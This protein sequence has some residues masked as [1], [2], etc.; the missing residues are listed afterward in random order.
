[1]EI[2]MEWTWATVGR[3]AIVLTVA[4]IVTS[5]GFAAARESDIRI[6]YGPP[7]DAAQQAM[8]RRL[9]DRKALEDIRDRLGDI[10]LP[11][12]LTIKIADCHGEVDASYESADATVTI[13]YEYL[14]YLQELAR[15]LPPAALREGLT[16]ESYLTGPF[17][18]VVLH[19]LAHALFDLKKIPILG[20]EEDAADQVAALT[21]LRLG[22]EQARRAIAAI[23]IMY[24][25]EAKAEAPTASDFANEH[26]LP[27]Q[28]FYN[29]LCISYG[30]DR[31]TFG[32][33]V[34]KGYL[35]SDRAEQCVAEYQQV[36][37]AFQQLIA[38]HLKGR[39]PT[40]TPQQR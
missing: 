5:A 32:D 17:L 16:P 39:R 26:S 23:A 31:K 15:D 13:C 33:L 9:Q 4:G 11:R 14:D 34:E 10:R 18:E 27:A 35:P 36:A 28:R 6:V 24:A 37:Y 40:A 1:M 25:S 8:Q 7:S 21:L 12:V 22:S 3:R 20:R 2:P 30:A 19:E 29:L 38:P